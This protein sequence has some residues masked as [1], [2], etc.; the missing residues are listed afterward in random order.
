MK[1]YA[2]YMVY[3]QVAISDN[4]FTELRQMKDIVKSLIGITERKIRP[5]G[6]GCAQFSAYIYYQFRSLQHFVHSFGEFCHP[7]FFMIDI[8][9]REKEKKTNI[10]TSCVHNGG[11][12]WES[13]VLKSSVDRY[14][15]IASSIGNVCV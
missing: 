14:I 4:N 10:L 6:R 7:P 3:R 12:A 15:S 8:R 1:I 9:E 2:W 5:T 13:S 11:G